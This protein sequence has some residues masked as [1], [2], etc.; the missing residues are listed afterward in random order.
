MHCNAGALLGACSCLLKCAP[1]L[2]LR[3]AEP[4]VL[5]SPVLS[6]PIEDH[7]WPRR[8]GHLMPQVMSLKVQ[9]WTQRYHC[10]WQLIAVGLV[11]SHISSCDSSVSPT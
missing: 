3:T 2:G 5:A 9:I 4:H 1:L 10:G 11:W 8:E 6:R 7:L